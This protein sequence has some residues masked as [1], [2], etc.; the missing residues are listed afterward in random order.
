MKIR[1]KNV[2]IGYTITLFLIM[3]L[4]CGWVW[5]SLDSFQKKYEQGKNATP[6]GDIQA[7]E[8]GR[9]APEMITLSFDRTQELVD[10]IEVTAY[11]S[12]QIKKEGQPAVKIV[13]KELDN[14]L[15]QDYSEIS[16]TELR[17]CV[18]MIDAERI[19]DIQVLDRYGNELQAAGADY[20]TA[21]FVENEQ[22]AQTA[23]GQFEVY[24]KHISKMVTLEELQ[25]VMRSS[26]KAY[27]AVLSSQKSLE[28][29]IAAKEMNFTRE[30]AA[31]MWM[32]DE[33]HMICDIHIDLTKITEN[34]RIVSETVDYQV[35][36]EQIQG[37]WYIYSFVILEQE[38]VLPNS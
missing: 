29:M 18:Y 17:Q 35:L 9:L 11:S 4:V 28:W 27:K 8:D 3:L 30:E 1:F 31:N 14:P 20:T 6:A 10:G 21:L 13:K 15:L 34:N 24:L 5:K 25:S 36:F 16:G 22:L 37:K 32:P 12:M 7:E 19:E 26:S 38:N 23:I 33:N 2:V